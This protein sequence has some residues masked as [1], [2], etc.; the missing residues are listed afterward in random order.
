MSLALANQLCNTMNLPNV[1]KILTI[2]AIVPN[3]F[4]EWLFDSFFSY[5]NKVLFELLLL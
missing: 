3:C 4:I 1:R 5:I 2:G